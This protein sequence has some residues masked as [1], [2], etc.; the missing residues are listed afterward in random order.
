MMGMWEESGELAH[1]YLKN[2]Q[3]IRGDAAFHQAAAKDAVGDI[4]VYLVSYCTKMGLNLTEIIVEGDANGDM[5]TFPHPAWAM[6]NGIFAIG[7]EF[8]KLMN[9]H[10]TNAPVEEIKVAIYRLCAALYVFAQ[11]Y[12]SLSCYE[13][14]FVAWDEVKKRDWKV[15]PWKGAPV[16]A[17]PVFTCSVCGFTASYETPCPAC[18]AKEYGVELP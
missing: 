12:V 10:V 3:N 17:E 18:R 11:S 15:N 2:A 13:C 4:M 9:L 8:F 5:Q 7:G 14:L 16:E 6:H 1:A